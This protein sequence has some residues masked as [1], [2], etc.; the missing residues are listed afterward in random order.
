MYAYYCILIIHI[1]HVLKFIHPP[2]R[3]ITCDNHG[4]SQ[5]FRNLQRSP[6]HLVDA[7]AKRKG[8]AEPEKP[9]GKAQT[10]GWQPPQLDSA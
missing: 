1:C 9:E 4:F 3:V 5:L 10:L 7:M 8:D 6:R 2:S